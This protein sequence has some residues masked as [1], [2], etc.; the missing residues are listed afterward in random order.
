MARLVRAL[1][2]AGACLA[3][4]AHASSGPP[5]GG[6][7]EGGEDGAARSIVVTATKRPVDILDASSAISILPRAVLDIASAG[8]I[9]GLGGVLPSFRAVTFANT[10]NA[11]FIIRGFGNGAF[12]PGIEPSVG[13]F[14]DGVY[15]SRAGATISDLPD[16]E[17]VEM[18][19]GPQSTLFGKNASAGVLSI[20]TRAPRF[21]LGGHGELSAG[22]RGLRLIKG[23]V[24]GPLANDLAVSLEGGRRID[25]G[26]GAIPNLR[27][28]I[29]DRDRWWLR[30][31]VLFQ[32]TSAIRLRLIADTE[33]LDEQCCMVTNVV[34]GPAGA[35]IRGLGGAYAANDP[36]SDRMPANLGSPNRIRNSGLS[37]QGDLD[38][39][40]STI[41]TIS[42]WRHGRHFQDQDADFTSADL[43]A[44]NAQDRTTRTFTQELR[45]TSDPH[46][47][48][49]FMVGAFVLHESVAQTAQLKMGSQFRA[50]ADAMVRWQSNN[51]LDADLIEAVAGVA[52]GSFWRAG[53]G[54]DEAY[55]LR[56]DSGTLYANAD[57]DLG[58]RVTLSLGAAYIADR[59][60]G[61]ARILSSDAFSAVDLVE[62]GRNGLVASIVGE[63][64]ALQRVATAQEVAQFAAAQPAPYLAIQA[65]AGANAGLS[66]Q[67]AQ[68]DGDPATT[69]G[70]GLL[71]LRTLQFLPPFLDYPNAVESGVTRD[72]KPTWSVRLNYRPGRRWNAFVNYA[73]G[74]KASSMN[75]SRDSR[76]SLAD[77][78]AVRELG[79]GL[80]NLVAGTRFAA[81]ESVRLI[82]AGMRFQGEGISA[83]V[84]LFDQRIRDFQTTV[85][86]GNAFVLGNAGAQTTRGME[87]EGSAALAPWLRIDAAL[88]YL[89]ARYDDYR[90]AQVVEGQMV[91][92]SGRRVA[93]VAR[94]TGTVAATAEWP[95]PAGG[96][97][98]L[99]LIYTRESPVEIRNDMPGIA[100]RMRDLRGSLEWRPASGV[101]LSI[102]GRNLLDDRWLMQTFPGVLQPGTVSGYPNEPRRY[103]ITLR[104]RR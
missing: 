8:D 74:F 58:E 13:I 10:I 14:V 43:L 104:L 57:V 25:E 38:L 91:D 41:T 12:G 3:V 98:L 44:R 18:L 89:D 6:D 67:E 55:R 42:A 64:L 1:A 81:P 29:N 45:W 60:K 53:Q 30:G 85:F 15:R 23:G 24:T 94:W 103:G 68:A 63:A 47:P 84:T 31:Q 88:T 82:E 75:L 4:P 9:G 36:F 59:K 86:V 77:M 66:P 54:V 48:M 46:R 73:T 56:N 101:A 102:W 39:G 22:N 80:P 52:P 28:R 96:H 95:V 97:V 92:Y 2:L 61:R 51:R 87:L 35:I 19:K 32:P 16:V 27:R 65:F 11:N 50:Y 5:L 79:L 69:V 49:R 71:A 62:V 90:D 100:R 40:G 83:S 93:G 21:D 78:G 76:P 17:R 33:R 7:G 20:V 70:N 34:D 26:Y 99:G 72:G 37:L